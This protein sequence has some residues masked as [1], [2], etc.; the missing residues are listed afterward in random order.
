M[1][2]QVRAEA[3]SRP[4][5]AD[6]A[7]G[8]VTQFRREM[9][10]LGLPCCLGIDSALRVIAANADQGPVAA[11]GPVGR[12]STRAKKLADG[13]LKTMRFVD[14]ARRRRPAFRNVTWRHGSPG[15]M[16]SRF[17]GLRVRHA[18]RALVGIEPLEVEAC[19]LSVESPTDAERPPKFFFWNLSATA[20]RKTVVR[21]AKCRWWLEHSY[22]EPKVELAF[23]HLF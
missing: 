10:A 3:F 20:Y 22:K 23:D 8:T 14:W 15:L 7:D 19:W 1:I 12:M 4:V 21:L 16:S 6:I 17:A 11:T 13:T 2:R 9:D 5:L 18:H